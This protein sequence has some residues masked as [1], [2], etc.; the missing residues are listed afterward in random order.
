MYWIGDNYT[1]TQAN[2]AMLLVFYCGA[3]MI[4]LS[5]PLEYFSYH[6]LYGINTDMVSSACDWSDMV[7]LHDHK[8][9]VCVGR[10]L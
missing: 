7:C 2:F 5:E 6:W 8:N 4:V 3:V 10:L 9:N 1:S